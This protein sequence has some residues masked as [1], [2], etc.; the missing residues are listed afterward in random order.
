MKIIRITDVWLRS[1]LVGTIVSGSQ[2]LFSPEINSKSWWCD[3]CWDRRW[4]TC[5]SYNFS[6]IVCLFVCFLRSAWFFPPHLSWMSLI[7][8]ALLPVSSP[9]SHLHFTSVHFPH[10]CSSAWLHLLLIPSSVQLS[11]ESSLLF[12]LYRLICLVFHFLMVCLLSLISLFP[13]PRRCFCVCLMLLSPLSR[14]KP[15]PL[16]FLSVV[17]HSL[18]HLPYCRLTAL[19]IQNS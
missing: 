4:T 7:G 9:P 2:F 15:R 12:S 10:L 18:I 19:I 8:S 17:S 11:C 13:S 14:L 1:W 3:V 6:F 5:L 16:H